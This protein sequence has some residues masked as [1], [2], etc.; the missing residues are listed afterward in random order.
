VDNRSSRDVIRDVAIELFGQHGYEK[1]SLREIADRVGMTKASLYYHFPSKQA[2]LLAILEPLVA[3]WRAVVDR[4]EALPHSREN[5]RLILGETL[6][7]QLRHRP[8][9]SLFVRDTAA[10]VQA[11]GPLFED[12]MQLNL[13]LHGWLAGPSPKPRD[14][15]RAVAATEALGAALAWSPIIR[16]VT[17][18]E[19]REA[20]LAAATAIL[21]SGD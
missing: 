20:L 7:V 4:A 15:V 3:Q 21:D 1:T 12:L 2:L 11:I 19:I 13:R 10:V 18:A 6:D 16:E 9:A 14:R 5:V 17:D 8:I